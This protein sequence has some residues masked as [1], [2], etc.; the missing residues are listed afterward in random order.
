MTL[1]SSLHGVFGRQSGQ[2]EGED[3]Y[4]PNN[5]FSASLT[6]QIVSSH[7]ILN[8]WV[9]YCFK[10]IARALANSLDPQ[11]SRLLIH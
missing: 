4:S 1:F 11:M 6:K 7:L 9:S 5:I 8:L 10:C 2:V 3:C